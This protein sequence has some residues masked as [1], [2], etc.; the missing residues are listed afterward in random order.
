VTEDAN[1]PSGER[2]GELTRLLQAA[3]R[4][5]AREAEAVLPLVYED[6]KKIARSQLSR[7]RPGQTLDT[8]ALVHEGYAKL[9]GGAGLDVENR[10]HY[11]AIAAQAM[12][13]VVVDYARGLFAA[14]RQHVRL[15]VDLSHLPDDGPAR[16]EQVAVVDQLLERLEMLD[17]EMVR[18]VECRFFAAYTLD[19]TADALSISKRTVQRKWDRARAWLA[20]LAREPD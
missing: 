16:A 1:R 20:A 4:G 2:G 15:D 12:R 6:L 17:P 10:R 7:W 8:T 5:G 9:A 18:I 11:F 13:Q 14:K 19:E 3:G